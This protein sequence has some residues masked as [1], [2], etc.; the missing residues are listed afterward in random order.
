MFLKHKSLKSGRH[1]TQALEIFDEKKPEAKISKHFLSLKN[2]VNKA[3]KNVASKSNK[4]RNF[5]KIFF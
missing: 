4:H 2:D 3:S 1:Q 5:K